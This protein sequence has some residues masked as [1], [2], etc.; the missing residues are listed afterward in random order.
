MLRSSNDWH[1][2]ALR[3]QV[4]HQDKYLQ[5]SKGRRSSLLQDDTYFTEM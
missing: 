3:T 4:H 2:H 5:V 1:L